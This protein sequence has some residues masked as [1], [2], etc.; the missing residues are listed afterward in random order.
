[1]KLVPLALTAALVLAVSAC[2]QTK[3]Y[4]GGATF[5]TKEEALAF[6]RNVTSATVQQIQPLPS[7]IADTLTIVVPTREHATAILKAGNPNLSPDDLDYLSDDAVINWS[8]PGQQ[9]ERRGSFK[10]VIIQQAEAPSLADIK[11]GGYLLWLKAPT[12]AQFFF[13]VAE[14]GATKT[15]QLELRDLAASSPRDQVIN[16]LESLEQYVRTHPPQKF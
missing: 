16:F 14:R 5:D 7:P 1:M 12:R 4:A 6:T 8:L 3:F 9:V 15:S 11:P 10:R 2:Q 13:H